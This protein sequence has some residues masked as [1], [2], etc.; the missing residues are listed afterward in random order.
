M[1]DDVTRARLQDRVRA[2]TEKDGSKKILVRSSIALFAFL[3]LLPKLMPLMGNF[4]GASTAD[5]EEAA[6]MVEAVVPQPGPVHDRIRTTGNVRANA[7]INL[8]SEVSG[9]VTRIYFREGTVVRPGQLL[10]KINDSEL[11]AELR[12]AE[13]SLELMRETEERQRKLL[14]SGGASREEYNTTRNE[15]NGLEAEVEL[16]RAQIARTEIRA[17]FAG[18][19]G[20]RYIDEGS[21]ISPTTRIATLQDLDAIKI[22]FSISERYMG[23]VHPGTPLN[24]RVQGMDEVLTGEVYAIEPQIDTRTRTA[25]IRAQS[26]NPGGMLRPGAFASVDLIIAS[27]D[28]AVMVPS[29]ALVPGVSGYAVFVARDGRAVETPVETG[30]RTSD[31]VH[32]T[33]GITPG[34]TVLTSGMLQVGNGSLVDVTRAVVLYPDREDRLPDPPEVPDPSMD[35][36]MPLQSDAELPIEPPMT[37]STDVDTPAEIDLN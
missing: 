8:S 32:I 6:I 28:D 27:Y 18:V 15:L 13:F 36:T 12:R 2:W 37:G 25:M 24:F 7:S 5:V 26:E 22:D 33:H 31:L 17:P 11:Q 1:A 16:I 23:H 30:T 34:D 19:L 4:G 10:V 3:L 35:A 14:E 21:Y 20:L 29:N 9:M